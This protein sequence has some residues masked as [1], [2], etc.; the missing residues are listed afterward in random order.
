MNQLLPD[1]VRLNQRIRGVQGSDWVHRMLPSWNEFM[2][3]AEKMCKSDLVAGLLNMDQ[4][5]TSL[6]NIR[7]N[8]RPQ[9]AIDPD[10]KIVMRSL[11]FYRFLS[12]NAS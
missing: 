8:P 12:S 2:D 10:M 6:A 7:N 9:L 5:R 11:V 3:Q 1:K 4:I